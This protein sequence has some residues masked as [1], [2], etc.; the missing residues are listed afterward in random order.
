MNLE[1][2]QNED[3]MKLKISKLNSLRKVQHLGGGIKSIEKL[4]SQGKLT[5]RERI[6]LLLDKNTDSIEIGEFTGYEM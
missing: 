4:H 5:A 2:N 3:A 1:A 6:D